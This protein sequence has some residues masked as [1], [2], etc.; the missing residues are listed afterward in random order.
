M[1]R[2][3]S[4]IL[5]IGLIAWPH[6]DRIGR[7]LERGIVWIVDAPEAL[8]KLPVLTPELVSYIMMAMGA[9]F[10][11]WGNLPERY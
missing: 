6:L 2:L 1:W 9:I 5:G 10:L 8:E 7:F 4:N 11:L 3:V